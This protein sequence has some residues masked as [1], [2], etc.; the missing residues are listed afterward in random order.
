[1]WMA[2]GLGVAAPDMQTTINSMIFL[3][4]AMA[5]VI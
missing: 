1:M 2:I 5:R 4:M 3:R